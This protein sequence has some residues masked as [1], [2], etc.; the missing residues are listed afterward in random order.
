ML[1]Q[2]CICLIISIL[3]LIL[4]LSYKPNGI[5]FINLFGTSYNYT[6]WS[7]ST[8]IET[9]YHIIILNTLYNMYTLKMELISLHLYIYNNNNKM[10]YNI[11]Y[12][13]GIL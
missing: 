6:F 1:F 11:Q 5:P 7:F 12:K 8:K 4:K 2:F 3:I 13:N 10:E 9:E